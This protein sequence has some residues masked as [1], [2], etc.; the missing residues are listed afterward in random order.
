MREEGLNFWIDEQDIDFGEQIVPAIL[1]GI[2][3]SDLSV[4]FISNATLSSKFS[5]FEIKTV[6]SA[7]LERDLKWLI[8]RLN[9]VN[10]EDILPSLGQYKYFNLKNNNTDD[11]I[12]AIKV[13][14]EK[15]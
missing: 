14:L 5:K 4:L 11:L 10:P 6:V 12:K 15:C 7:M 3:E 9:D 2:A 13:K 1:Q 8:V